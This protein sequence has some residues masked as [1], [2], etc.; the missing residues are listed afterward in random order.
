MTC[1]QIFQS[2]GPRAEELGRLLDERLGD[3]IVYAYVDDDRDEGTGPYYNVQIGDA[4]RYSFE[5]RSKITLRWRYRDLKDLTEAE[6]RP[7]TERDA[8]R[9]HH[10]SG[11]TREIK[12]ETLEGSIPYLS[13]SYDGAES[14][15]I[16]PGFFFDSFDLFG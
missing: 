15:P 8:H 6:K 14:K 16:Y 7:A 10:S 13:G 9:W 2:Y 11:F 4:N 1:Q 5:L 12:L 3:R